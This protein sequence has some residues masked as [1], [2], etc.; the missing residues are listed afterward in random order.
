MRDPRITN[1]PGGCAWQGMLLLV[2]GFYFLFGLMLPAFCWAD[3][4][5]DIAA[6]LGAVFI[7]IAAGMVL[8]NPWPW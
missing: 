2:A 6:G 5:W 4:C 3:S 7:A 1:D 8:L